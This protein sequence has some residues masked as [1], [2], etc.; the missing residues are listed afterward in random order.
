MTVTVIEIKCPVC[1]KKNTQVINDSKIGK[2]IQLFICPY[3]KEMYTS[4]IEV[5]NEKSE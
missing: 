1:K 2:Y 3:C 4:D 5:K